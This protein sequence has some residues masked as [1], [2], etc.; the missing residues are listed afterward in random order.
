MARVPAGVPKLPP[1]ERTAR[2]YC[3]RGERSTDK[4]TGE[5]YQHD[6]DYQPVYPDTVIEELRAGEAAFRRGELLSANPHKA[7]TPEW[8]SWLDGHL[9]AGNKVCCFR[10]SQTR[11]NGKK[12]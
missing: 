4:L 11:K 10:P 9:W 8:H 2:K 3:K 1:L 12:A 7:G 6:P 5:S